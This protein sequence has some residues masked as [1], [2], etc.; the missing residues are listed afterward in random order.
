MEAADYFNKLD[1]IINL[2][3][4]KIIFIS[5]SPNFGGHAVRRILSASPEIFYPINPLSYPDDLEGFVA[6][7]GWDL[8]HSFTKQHLGACHE[9]LIQYPPTQ[10][11]EVID[12]Y[13]YIKKCEKF[14]IVT[15]DLHI[16][17]KFNCT[18]IRLFGKQPRRNMWDGR[19]D[20]IDPIFEKNVINVDVDNLFSDRYEKFEKEYL[21]LCKSLNIFPQI[22][23]VRAFILLWL[24][25]QKRLSEFLDGRH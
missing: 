1:D 9:D 13:K 3:S 7:A 6:H 25:K 12:F 18:T 14:C 20:V 24:E 16:H 22:N 4:H 10:L 19:P 21:S 23:S 2:T 8:P 11:S 5:Y 15:H 17:K